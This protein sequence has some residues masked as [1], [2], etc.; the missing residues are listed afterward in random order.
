[1]KPIFETCQAAIDL[2]MSHRYHGDEPGES[3]GT[4][5]RLLGAQQGRADRGSYAPPQR[6]AQRGRAARRERSHGRG[7]RRRERTETII[8]NVTAMS[9]RTVEV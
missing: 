8:S 1:M 6:A 9:G 4:V 2:T 5:A 7:G 3:V